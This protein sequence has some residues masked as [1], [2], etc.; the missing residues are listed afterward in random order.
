MLCWILYSKELVGTAKVKGSLGCSDREMVKFR[1][2]RGRTRMKSRFSTLD[3]RKAVSSVS[4]KICLEA[5]QGIRLWN[6]E[7]KKGS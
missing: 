5:L 1:T 4:S 6:E 7:P 2:L 3:F